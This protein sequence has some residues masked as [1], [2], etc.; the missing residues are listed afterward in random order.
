VSSTIHRL[1][2]GSI[3]G[4]WLVSGGATSTI[5]ARANVP[6]DTALP[7]ADATSTESILVRRDLS[8]TTPVV[9]TDIGPNGI[10]MQSGALVP[11]FDVLVAE[12]WQK[13]SGTES[14]PVPSAEILEYQQTFGQ[15]W[16]LVRNRLARGETLD[17]ERMLQELVDR[18]KERVPVPACALAAQQLLARQMADRGD[19][20]AAWVTWLIARKKDGANSAVGGPTDIEATWLDVYLDR[21][22]QPA[23][24]LV[25]LPMSIP[26]PS[27]WSDAEQQQLLELSDRPAAALCLVAASL[28]AGHSPDKKSLQEVVQRSYA[29]ANDTQRAL[30]GSCLNTIDTIESWRANPEFLAT[31][32]VRFGYLEAE[33]QWTSLS[34]PAIE[35][36]NPERSPAP[37]DVE[38]ERQ[39][40]VWQLRLEGLFLNAHS[41]PQIAEAGQLRLLLLEHWGFKT[42]ARARTDK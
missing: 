10:V 1:L 28:N 3:L 20:A 22:N 25:H 13:I 27:S 16:F 7:K 4:L 30:L 42:Q 2:A 31:D 17:V 6:Q 29:Q 12:N 18:G 19:V 23:D 33:R 24:S 36:V 14:V 11:W 40:L 38:L 41:N 5:L 35:S 21:Y 9:V 39:K 8:V 32:Q 26:F 37:V 15:P 34:N